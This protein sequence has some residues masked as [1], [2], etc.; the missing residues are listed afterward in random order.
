[1]TL[2]F[3][4]F[5]TRWAPEI[6]NSEEEIWEQYEPTM[7]EYTIQGIDVK[8]FLEENRGFRH[9]Y[10]ECAKEKWIKNI[11]Y[12]SSYYQVVKDTNIKLVVEF[13]D[14]YIIK[15]AQKTGGVKFNNEDI[16]KYKQEFSIR[17]MIDINRVFRDILDREDGEIDW[18]ITSR[19]KLYI[20]DNI[21]KIRPDKDKD[22][23]DYRHIE[24]GFNVKDK[25]I[26]IT[27]L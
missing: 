13:I 27:I 16:L 12:K 1:M 21:I 3:H 20:R 8:N 6:W 2:I 4:K 11:D 22:Q 23:F 15:H 19:L 17:Q 9:C 5:N 24:Q 18:K 25:G 7:L 10:E 26:K 14:N